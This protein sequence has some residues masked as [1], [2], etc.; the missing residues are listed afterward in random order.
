MLMTKMAIILMLSKI[1][2]VGNN[3]YALVGGKINV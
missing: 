1:F 3:Y 2:L